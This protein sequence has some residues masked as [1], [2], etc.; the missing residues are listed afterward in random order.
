MKDEKSTETP[1]KKGLKSKEEI[2]KKWLEQLQPV[3]V[4]DLGAN[5]GKFSFLAAPFTK[6]LIAM[7]SDDICVDLM[8]AQIKK[9][10]FCIL[11]KEFRFKYL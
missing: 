8:E 11:S 2:V 9:Q 6:R 10:K 4:L 1:I 3:S 5:T 7:E